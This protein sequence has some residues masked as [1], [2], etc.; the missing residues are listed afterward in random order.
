M[1]RKLLGIVLLLTVAIQFL[2]VKEIGGL[3]F[4]NMLTEELCD[5]VDQESKEAS[6]ESKKG[7]DDLLENKIQ[8]HSAFL[9]DSFNFSDKNIVFRSRMADDKPTRPPLLVWKI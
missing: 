1:K 6:K 2:P 3:F 8:D 7:F 9:I 5:A 4:N